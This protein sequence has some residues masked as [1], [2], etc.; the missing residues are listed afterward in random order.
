MTSSTTRWGRNVVDALER[1]AARVGDLDLE[2]LVA[3]SHGEQVG[4]ALLVV[5][6]QDARRLGH[7]TRVSLTPQPVHFL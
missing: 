3:Q 7:R 4:D 1:L 2:A 5:D 6:D